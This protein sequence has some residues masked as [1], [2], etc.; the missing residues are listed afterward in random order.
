MVISALLVSL[1]LLVVL[2]S[3]IIGL[4]TV[5]QPSATSFGVILA[6]FL[7]QNVLEKVPK[8]TLFPRPLAINVLGLLVSAI[9]NSSCLTHAVGR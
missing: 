9:V 7:E 5:A 4:T 6:G 8:S 1:G 3:M 2:Q